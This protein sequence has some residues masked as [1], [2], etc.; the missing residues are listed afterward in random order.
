MT[1]NLESPGISA[2]SSPGYPA[3]GMVSLQEQ[4]LDDGESHGSMLAQCI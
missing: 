4:R 3:S 1:M 2:I